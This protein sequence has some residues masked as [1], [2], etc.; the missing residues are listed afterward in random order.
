MQISLQLK[1]NA[2]PAQQLV[3]YQ[4][5]QYIGDADTYVILLS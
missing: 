1:E 2:Q 5:G 3:L 4:S